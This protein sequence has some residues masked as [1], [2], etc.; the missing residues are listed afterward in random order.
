MPGMLER[1]GRQVPDVCTASGRRDA[2]DGRAAASDRGVRAGG[3]AFRPPGRCSGRTTGQR[4]GGRASRGPGGGAAPSSAGR[5]SGSYSAR[6]TRSDRPSRSGYARRRGRA[7]CRC[8]ARAPRATSDAAADSSA[9]G[10]SSARALAV[11]RAT[12]GHAG[13]RAAGNGAFATRR[14]AGLRPG[15]RCAHHPAEATARNQLRPYRNGIG[16]GAGADGRVRNAAATARA[17]GRE[18]QLSRSRC[19]AVPKVRPAAFGKGALLPPLRERPGKL[20]AV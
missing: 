4:A 8:A 15:H 7:R 1:G 13:R 11:E 6:R 18:R 17:T 19:S 16:P 5:R 14:G 9:P 2:R 12:A 20:G 10:V 3:R